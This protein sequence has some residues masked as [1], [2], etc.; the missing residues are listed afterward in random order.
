MINIFANGLSLSPNLSSRIEKLS[1]EYINLVIPGT[2][3]LKKVSEEAFVAKT[4]NTLNE[5]T[6]L[7]KG[8]SAN[9]AEAKEKA[10]KGL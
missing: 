8:Y 4:A 9:K 7:L 6:T 10:T 3:E 1:D 5:I 2:R